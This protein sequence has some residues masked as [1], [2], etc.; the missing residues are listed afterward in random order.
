MVL[1]LP[2]KVTNLT[3]LIMKHTVIPCQRYDGARESQ[4][5]GDTQVVLHSSAIIIETL[6]ISRLFELFLVELGVE[7]TRSRL[8]LH[9]HP[10]SR[11]ALRA[12]APPPR[13]PHSS[14]VLY[15]L[16]LTFYSLSISP[17]SGGFSDIDP[18]QKRDAPEDPTPITFPAY[19]PSK[20]TSWKV[21]SPT[22]DLRFLFSRISKPTDITHL[23]R[24]ALNIDLVESCPV[25]DLLLSANGVSFLPPLPTGQRE[26]GITTPG[27][28][29]ESV[30]AS[31]SWM[32]YEQRLS[33]LM[34]ENDLA[35]RS[36]TRRLPQGTKPCRLSHSRK[37]W[38]GLESMSS[39]WDCSL[40][41]YLDAPHDPAVAQEDNIENLSLNI[42]TPNLPSDSLP[43]P[44]KAYTAGPHDEAIPM[45]ENEAKGSGTDSSRIEPQDSLQ[46]V[47]STSVT[48][49]PLPKSQ[50][51]GRRIGTGREMPDQFRIDTVRGFVEC[52][53]F[54]FK[55]TLSP[56][57]RMPIV[58]L[59]KLNLPV[60]QTAAVYRM[61]QDRNAARQGCYEGPIIGVQVRS[62]TDFSLPDTGPDVFKARL[63]LM[64]EFG[65]LLQLAQE[66]RREGKNEV[67]PG[68]GMW[69][70]TVPRW[71][72]GPGGAVEDRINSDVLTSAETPGLAA[73]EREDPDF[74]SAGSGNRVRSR[75]TPAILW[76]ELRCGNGFWDARTDYK[77]IGKS[78]SSN[79]DEVCSPRTLP[80][81]LRKRQVNL[82]L[83]PLNKQI[84]L[85]SSLNTHIAILKLTVHTAYTD[86][87][88]TG[89][90]PSQALAERDWSCPRLQRTQWYDLFDPAQRAEAFRALWGVMAFLTRAGNDT[91]RRRKVGATSRRG[92][93]QGRRRNAKA[94]AVSHNMPLRLSIH[95]PPE[96]NIHFRMPD[97]FYHMFPQLCTRSKAQSKKSKQAWG[98]L[99]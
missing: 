62:D 41:E 57:R 83:M 87:L 25:D 45:C 15:S 36:L 81:P 5:P 78:P 35:F 65:G 92:Y 50:Y 37:F 8:E 4:Q 75:R 13:P 98:S 68:E 59:N 30:N 52:A 10:C 58:Q 67:K 19:E 90:L 2:E 27:A 79:Y 21:D 61:P 7:D 73:R 47:R 86:S 54:A 85:L 14:V 1:V 53:T 31:S 69:Y 63:D 96:V 64:R 42:A 71:G 51:K 70:T 28:R 55:C 91:A 33:E 32:D 3:M 34:I 18:D 97:A 94:Q 76:Q 80:P 38:V 26:H 12:A 66:R 84:F 40:D 49:E 39:Y 82:Q 60:R 46:D 72:G 24:E 16:L 99:E 89:T 23:H 11:D 44:R 74:R 17:M 48:P 93:C 6:V 77:A 95:F 56:P 22:P 9:R 43:L 20:T 88:I 29:G